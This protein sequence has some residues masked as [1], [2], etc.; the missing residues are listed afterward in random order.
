MRTLR[1]ATLVGF[2]LFAAGSVFANT[3]R[4]QADGNKPASSVALAANDSDAAATATP[5]AEAPAPA[6]QGAGRPAAGDGGGSA[7]NPIATT[8]GTLGLFTLE[9]GQ[10]LPK[11]GWSS[12]GYLNKFTRMPGSVTVLNLGVNFGYGITD[13]LTL[14]ADFEPYRH[15]HVSLPGE[16]SL[17][18]PS[19]SGALFPQYDGSIYRRLGP[20]SRPGYVEDYPFAANNDGGVGSI[21]VGLK[22]GLLSEDRGSRVSLSLRNDFLIPTRRSLTNLLEN[23]TQTGTFN[24]QL[25]FA[26]SK[27]WGNAVTLSGNIGYRFTADPKTSGVADF[28]SA[29]QLNG[30]AGFI[31]FPQSRLQVMSEYTT[32]V[33]TGRHTPDMTFGARDPVDGVWG[34]RV[35]INR[36]IAVDLGYRYMLNL[37]NARDRS[38]FVIKIGT[39]HLPEVVAAPVKANQSPAVSCSVDKASVIAGSNDVVNITA[40]ASDP[41]GDPITYGWTSTGG[42]VDGTGPQVRWAVGNLMPGNYTATVRVDD[43]RGGNATCSVSTAVATRP[44]RP[45]TVSLAPDRN[46]VLVGEKVHFTATANDP[47]GDPL[48]Y[49]WRTNGGQLSGTGAGNDLDTTGVAP[50][51]YTVTVRVDD[52]RGGAADAS[53]SVQVNAPPPPP[54]ASRIS[55]CDFKA[56]NSARVDN[57]CKRVLDDVALRMQNDPRAKIVI[58]GFADPRERRPDTM[59]GTR[60]TNAAQYLADKGVDRSRITNRTGAGQ[61]GA[62]QTNRRLDVVWVPDGATY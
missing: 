19:T 40:T 39:T 52:G 15:T 48:T 27:T 47:D 22:F 10:T 31:L 42:N 26:L 1:S 51:S 46:Q 43:G 33:F 29:D 28:H 50:G 8:N 62:G 53:A 38:G 60:G 37:S 54:Q 16:L 58:V 11:G 9:S 14:Y 34:V 32:T 6:A 36:A 4:N 17:R 12:A 24:D 49:M 7:V 5:E 57:V 56:V 21:T 55:G 18:T 30:G 23:G 20:R 45:P 3:P 35:Y 41:D 61:A 2:L 44:N 13:R 25:T 59:A